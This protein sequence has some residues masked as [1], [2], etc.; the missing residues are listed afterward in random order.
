MVVSCA[1]AIYEEVHQLVS[2]LRPLALD[3]FGLQDALQDLLEDARTR[4]PQ[5]H[6]SL[7]VDAPLDTLADGLSTATYRIMQ[8]SLT[9]ALRHA[10]ASKIDMQVSLLDDALYLTVRDN[11]LGPSPDWAQSGHYGVIG[12]RERAEGLGGSLS[13]EALSPSGVQVRAVLPLR[14]NQHHV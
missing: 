7:H 12:M 13:F 1:D 8:E 11:G 6:L 2:K 3:R 5:V 14:H 4:H 10:Q 9:N